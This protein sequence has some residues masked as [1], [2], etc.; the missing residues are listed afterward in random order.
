MDS[1]ANALADPDVDE[2][3]SC[4]LKGPVSPDIEQ[5]LL[6]S[7]AWRQALLTPLSNQVRWV[8]MNGQM[9]NRLRSELIGEMNRSSI[10][11]ST[12]VPNSGHMNHILKFAGSSTQPID[13]TTSSTFPSVTQEES[14]ELPSLLSFAKSQNASGCRNSTPP[15]IAVCG[16]EVS[17]ANGY[18][19][20]IDIQAPPF[21]ALSSN[22]T[23]QATH[24][25]PPNWEQPIQSDWS[26]KSASPEKNLES[27]NVRPLS[28]ARSRAGSVYNNARLSRGINDSSQITSD[29]FEARES[30]QSSPSDSSD[31]SD[32]EMP[33]A[34]FNLQVPCQSANEA[35]S[36]EYH[37][38][39]R[40]HGSQR[41]DMEEGEGEITKNGSIKPI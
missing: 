8:L 18:P 19:T 12:L 32:I 29:H 27:E 24:Q 25:A 13:L 23:H 28:P 39:D 11:Q 33:D 16:N 34:D 9:S 26:F 36:A 3:R 38:V 22:S 30:Q 40:H 10:T 21:T 15:A 37:K 14:R 41:D 20:P 7:R 5:K 31:L 2:L 17:I 4:F 6:N 35:D 1:A